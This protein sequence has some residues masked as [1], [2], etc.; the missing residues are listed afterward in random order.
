MDLP[1]RPRRG[2]YDYISF[3]PAS[4]PFQSW[5]L[6]GLFELTLRH[7]RAINLTLCVAS[8]NTEI[9]RHCQVYR[10]KRKGPQTPLKTSVTM[11]DCVVVNKHIFTHS[12]LIDEKAKMV[13]VSLRPYVGVF[14][15]VLG[16]NR[17]S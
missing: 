4:L 6:E 15:L 3:L 14:R 1:G 11:F 10:T 7:S 9:K 8:R 17:E 5:T 16:G 2:R 12:I 13:E